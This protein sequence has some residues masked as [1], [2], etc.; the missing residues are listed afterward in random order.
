MSSRSPQLISEPQVLVGRCRDRSSG[1]WVLIG[2]KPQSRGAIEACKA[3]RSIAWEPHC[4][5]GEIREVIWSNLVVIA[6]LHC[7][8]L[9]SL[10]IPGEH[11]RW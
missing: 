3:R 5:A 1:P 9:S 6:I 7:R 10:S 4:C 11:L 8:S 2:R